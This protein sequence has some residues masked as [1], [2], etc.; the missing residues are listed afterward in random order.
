MKTNKYKTLEGLLYSYSTLPYKK[1]NIEIDLKLHEGE[2][3]KEKLK[4]L[5]EIEL[6]SAKI[7][8]MLEMLKNDNELEYLII[9]LRYIDKLSWEQIEQQLHMSACQLILRRKNIILDKLISMI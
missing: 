5:E 6:I 3:N 7:E 4:E 8:N 1:R 2:E 9:K